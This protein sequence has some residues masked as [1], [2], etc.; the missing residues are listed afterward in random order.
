MWLRDN[1]QDSDVIGTHDVG[2]IGFY[3]GRKIVDI[4]G[5]ITPELINKISEDNYVSYISE[6]MKQSGVT[7]LALQK[8]W[9]RVVNQPPVFSKTTPSPVEKVD[10]F[11]YYPDKTHLLS[12]LVNSVIMEAEGRLQTRNPQQVQSAVQ[13]LS[14]SLQYD[15]NSS[16][17]YLMLAYGSSLQNDN[18]GTEKYLLKALEIYPDYSEVLLQLGAF[19]KQNKPEKSKKYLER[20]IKLNP[21]DR[22]AAEQLNAVNNLL[23]SK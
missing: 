14:R 13:M 18:A 6:F 23:K 21:S 3:S 4:A 8:E 2:A 11:K 12:R 19:Y 20:Y 7:Y 16:L 9:Y 5:L 10:V 22:K 17:T 1:T 15:P